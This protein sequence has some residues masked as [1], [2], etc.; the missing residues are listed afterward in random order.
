MKYLRSG[1][2]FLTKLAERGSWEG[3]ETAGRQ[4]LVEKAQAEAD[5]ILQVHQVP[6]LEV[7]QER[8]LNAIMKAAERE[9][10]R[11]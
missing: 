4:G 10:V 2:V 6:P 8:E 1:E 3:W 5:R 9:L 7:A 11:H